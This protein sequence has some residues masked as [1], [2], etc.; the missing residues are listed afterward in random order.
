MKNLSKQDIRR[1]AMAY[2]MHESW[3]YDL[4]R[5][6][7][8]Y[9]FSNSAKRAIRGIFNKMVKA[10]LSPST[11]RDVLNGE[12]LASCE[13]LAFYIRFFAKKRNTQMHGRDFGDELAAEWNAQWGIPYYRLQDCLYAISATSPD[14]LNY[15]N[16]NGL[17]LISF[18]V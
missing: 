16:T 18:Y 1:L 6:A 3:G 7:E 4:D 12:W 8:H 14:V 5:T 9:G 15:T 13:A 11:A 10:K 17:D 2:R